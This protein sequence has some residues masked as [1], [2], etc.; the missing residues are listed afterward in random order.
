MNNYK[1]GLLEL[2]ADA[3]VELLVKSVFLVYCVIKPI[4]GHAPMTLPLS[5]NASELEVTE[6]EISNHYAVFS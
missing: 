1:I 4:I 5:K 2:W 6:S 3:L